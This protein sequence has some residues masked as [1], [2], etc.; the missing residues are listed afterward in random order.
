MKILNAIYAHLLLKSRNSIFKMEGLNCMQE[1][2]RIYRRDPN[3]GCTV[4]LSTNMSL[5]A[6]N[7]AL[8]LMTKDRIGLPASLYFF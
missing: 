1:K 6:N 2:D 5:F 3:T 7:D 4:V 8:A